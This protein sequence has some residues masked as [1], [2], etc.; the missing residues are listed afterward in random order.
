M[1]RAVSQNMR[2]SGSLREWE[3]GEC[4]D[5]LSAWSSAKYF[6]PGADQQDLRWQGALLADAALGSR[7]AAL[8]RLAAV[9][10]G[11]TD[12]TLGAFYGRLSARIGKVKAIIATARKIALRFY[13]A[14]RH[15]G[16]TTRALPKFESYGM[17]ETAASRGWKAKD[18]IEW[19]HG[20]DHLG[21]PGAF[22]CETRYR[23]RVIDNLSACQSLGLVLQRRR[24]PFLRKSSATFSFCHPPYDFFLPGLIGEGHQAHRER[25]HPT[26][27]EQYSITPTNLA[28]RARWQQFVWLHP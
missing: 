14:M 8:L 1:K 3:L 9:T 24:R 4:G 11:R 25:V 15:T 18:A 26:R 16:W 5:D 2:P 20:I 27:R 28:R 13:N 12:T 17:L 22:S 23:A 21:R 10:I 7:A 6:T 19:F